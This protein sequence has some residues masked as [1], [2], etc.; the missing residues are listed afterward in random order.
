M[1]E[2]NPPQIVDKETKSTPQWIHDPSSIYYLHPSEG[3]GMSLTTY[4]LTGDNYD[5]WAKAI[6]S[7]LEGKNKLEFVNGQYPPPGDKASSEYVVW[8]ANNSTICGWLFNSTDSN[9][10]SSI[11][12]HNI[13]SEMW[14][15]LKERY[16]IVNRPRIHQL[17]TEYHT[18]R[19]KGMN[20]TSFYN[21][22]KSLWD[23]LY[24]TEDVTC[25]CT[26]AAATH[27][28]ARVE[29]DKTHDF[30]MGLDDEQYGQIR[31]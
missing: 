4:V 7:G 24:G 18:L 10:Q 17:K 8:R 29:V 20:V 21:K 22:F 19:Q 9:I 26:C 3:P 28:R 14:L 30:L 15:D 16:S 2:N 23:E 27:I 11:A 1:S 31:T 6:F 12:S 5:V 25:G 13:V